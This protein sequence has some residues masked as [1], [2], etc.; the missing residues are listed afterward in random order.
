MAAEPGL[1]PTRS[2]GRRPTRR[3]RSSTAATSRCATFAIL[4]AGHFGISGDRRRQP[5][6]SKI[7]D[8]HQPRRHQRRLLPQCAHLQLQREFAVGR[9]YLP[10][11]ARSRS[12][13]HA[14]PRTSRSATATS[15]AVSPSARCSMAPSDASMPDAAQPTGRIKCGTESNGGFKN[16]TI[17][18]CV[19]ESCRGF[20]LESGRRRAHR[21]HHV[22]RAS[23]CATSAMRR[24]FCG[25]ARACARPA[26]T[27]IGTFKRVII[28]NIIC[29]AP[30]NDMP[31]IIAGVP[32]HSDRGRQRQRCIDGAE[33]RL[34]CCDGRHR[35]SGAGAGVP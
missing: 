25:S 28:S 10:R 27:G 21:G 24:C 26:G 19:F 4:A 12:A 30:A 17:G 34:F 15:R 5:D 23:P 1:P 31:A 29:D 16:I 14:R 7:S 3:S 35:S 8:R 20:A 32:G 13:M 6:A 22:H 2:A 33:G 11:R 18:N 9:W